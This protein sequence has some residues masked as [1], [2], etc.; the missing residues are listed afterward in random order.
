MRS[1][2]DSL[3]HL[4]HRYVYANCLKPKEGRITD[5]KP[6]EKLLAAF[7]QLADGLDED[8]NPIYIDAQG[9][10]WRFVLMFGCGDMEQLCQGWGLKSYNDIHEMCGFCV[11]NRTDVLFTDLQ[12]DAAWRD[13]CP[14]PNDVM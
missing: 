8:G 10:Q 3:P 2:Q 4:Q 1:Q 11:A 12:E 9:R 14:I 7:D 13:T 6:W 5:Q